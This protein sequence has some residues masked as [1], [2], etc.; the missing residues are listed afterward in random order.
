MKDVDGMYGCLAC[1]LE[2]KDEIYPAVQVARD[3]VTLQGLNKH[4]VSKEN[5]QG[6]TKTYLSVLENEESSIVARPGR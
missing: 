5:T 2:P 4:K 3:I 6:N 1:L